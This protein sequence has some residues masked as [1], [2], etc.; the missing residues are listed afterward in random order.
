M[1]PSPRRPIIN[2]CGPCLWSVCPPCKRYHL[3]VV[4]S[5]PDTEHPTAAVLLSLRN[6]K[7][8]AG[9]GT[10]TGSLYDSTGRDSRGPA[11]QCAQEVCPMV[12][13]YG[14]H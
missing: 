13:M 3:A 1:L 9:V 12:T 5:G 14:A 10:K 6:L 8:D 4:L 11:E 7:L 2:D